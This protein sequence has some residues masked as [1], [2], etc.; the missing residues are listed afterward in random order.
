[1]RDMESAHLRT[2]AEQQE[3]DDA[4]LWTQSVSLDTLENRMHDS[5]GNGAGV[6]QLA[7]AL[8][9]ALPVHAPPTAEGENRDPV[10]R[11]P[12]LEARA[13]L[14]LRKSLPLVAPEILA[15]GPPCA[16]S[17]V[18]PGM[19]RKHTATACRYTAGCPSGRR[20]YR[21]AKP[22]RPGT[23]PAQDATSFAAGERA[24]LLSAFSAALPGQQALGAL[25]S[26]VGRLQG[27]L[28]RE[29]EGWR[30]LRADCA[31]VAG[32]LEASA[33]RGRARRPLPAR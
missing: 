30:C 4:Q 31:H 3:E 22:S 29:A 12:S 2:T 15:P 25:L 9:G 6:A 17:S 11:E 13:S 32:A 33:G 1:L 14:W 10:A 24:A 18:P 23:L 8:Q 7:E 16:L 5:L 28:E 20:P 27:R 19:V 26:S 21:P